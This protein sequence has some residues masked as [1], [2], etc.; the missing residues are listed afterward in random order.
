METIAQTKGTR[1]EA[2]AD[3]DMSVEAQ[4][5]KKVVDELI[6]YLGAANTWDYLPV[7]RWFDVFGVRNKILA[8]VSR[9]DAFLHRLIDNERRRLDHAGTEGDK[10]SMIAV[11]LNL[12]KTEPEVYTDTMMTA[13]CAIC[14]N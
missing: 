7:L 10:K 11:L 12:Q 4:Q 5:F 8:A 3:T 14:D 6:P 1:S 13:L 2:D 9:R